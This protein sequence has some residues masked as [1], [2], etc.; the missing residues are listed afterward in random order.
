M[1]LDHLM[2]WLRFPD[3]LD[4]E[5]DYFYVATLLYPHQIKYNEKELILRTYNRILNGD[6]KKFPKEYFSGTRGA[7]RACICF[8]YMLNQHYAFQNAKEM[9]SFFSTN[10]G[11]RALKKYRLISI[12]SEIYDNKLDFL[13][14]SLPEEQ[15]D[16]YWYHYYKFME[17]YNALKQNQLQIPDSNL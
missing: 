7:L 12:C 8:Q 5:T 2:K 1:K 14:E 4:K 10:S 16:E 11:Y 15:Q 6:L 17:C 3:E 9:Y 13:N